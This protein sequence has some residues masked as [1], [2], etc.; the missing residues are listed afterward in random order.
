MTVRFSVPNWVSRHL[1]GDK[2][3]G[4][5]SIVNPQF[6]ALCVDNVCG[7]L[8]RARCSFV[9]HTV[10]SKGREHVLAYNQWLLF[11]FL[12]VD[13]ISYK[14]RGEMSQFSAYR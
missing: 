8:C 14:T 3:T 13:V 12:L 1:M 5:L 10:V 6:V 2:L 11:F 7:M 9:Q 4:S